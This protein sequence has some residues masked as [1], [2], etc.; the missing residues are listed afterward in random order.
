MFGTYKYTAEQKQIDEIWATVEL[1]RT[2][3]MDMEHA[4]SKV[5]FGNDSPQF[6]FAIVSIVRSFE[7]VHVINYS[8]S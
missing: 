5:K 3:R 8:H 2:Y 7:F 4:S 6:I 1:T